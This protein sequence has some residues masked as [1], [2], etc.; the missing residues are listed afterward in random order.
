MHHDAHHALV[1][2]LEDHNIVADFKLLYHAAALDLDVFVKVLNICRLDDYAT[3]IL[4]ARLDHPYE[5]LELSLHDS[6]S[7]LGGLTLVVVASFVD[8]ANDFLFRVY[9]V[10]VLVFNSCKH[11][12]FLMGGCD[13]GQLEYL[14]VYHFVEHAVLVLFVFVHV[15]P[16]AANSLPFKVFLVDVVFVEEP[17]DGPVGRVIL[18]YFGF[19]F[20]VVN[21]DVGV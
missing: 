20:L 19:V 7:F 11:F 18:A 9:F 15:E 1:V 5:A 3:S 12:D 2:A 6:N 16:F 14:D 4:L 21:V 17:L 10:V 13:I 8:G